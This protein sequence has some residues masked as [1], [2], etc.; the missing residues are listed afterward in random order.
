MHYN[1]VLFAMGCIIDRNGMGWCII[2]RDGM[3]LAKGEIGRNGAHGVYQC[4]FHDERTRYKIYYNN[5]EISKNV[6]EA[7]N[8]IKKSY[9]PKKTIIIPREN[10]A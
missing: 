4:E 5:I 1:A 6:K 10:V 7:K 8:K 2:N 9:S 3:Q